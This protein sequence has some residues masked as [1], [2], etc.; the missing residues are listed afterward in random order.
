V[1]TLLASTFPAFA[2]SLYDE[3]LSSL[4]GTLRPLIQA[5]GTP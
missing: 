1:L 4:S 5:K 3:E 2:Q